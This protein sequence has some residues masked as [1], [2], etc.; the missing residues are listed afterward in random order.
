LLDKYASTVAASDATSRPTPGPV[1]LGSPYDKEIARRQT[2]VGPQS[3][4]SAAMKQAA[5]ERYA[6]EKRNEKYKKAAEYAQV[7][8]GGLEVAAPF[9]GPLAPILGGAGTLASV[10]S[11]AYLAGRDVA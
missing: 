10:G 2:S 6:Q 9:T 5:E 7:I 11:S 4:T 1:F 8:G 3:K